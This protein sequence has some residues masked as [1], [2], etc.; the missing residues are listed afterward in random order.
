MR[1]AAEDMKCAA[2]QIEDSLQRFGMRMEEWI[3][4]L[5]AVIAESQSADTEGSR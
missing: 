3:S 5:E 2:N 4:R 1:S